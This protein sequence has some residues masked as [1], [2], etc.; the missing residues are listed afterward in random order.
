MMRLINEVAMPDMCCEAGCYIAENRATRYVSVIA[1]VF[2]EWY[3]DFTW[4]KSGIEFAIAII[5]AN[6]P[7]GELKCTKREQQIVIKTL[8]WP[9]Y[10]SR[11][12]RNKEMDR[13]LEKERTI[14]LNARW[15]NN[16][17]RWKGI[18]NRIMA[19]FLWLMKS[20]RSIWMAAI[21]G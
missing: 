5:R 18:G 9:D 17:I 4:K 19:Q 21:C 10:Q 8:I 6:L 11:R 3:A 14:T 16:I 7:V 12:F 15:V 1:T 2:G 20:N 13:S